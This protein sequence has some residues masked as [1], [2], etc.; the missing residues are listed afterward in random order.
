MHSMHE[1][2][3]T[4]E[5][6][7][8]SRYESVM[9]KAA[10]AIL[11]GGLAAA[12]AVFVTSPPDAAGDGPGVYVAS[13]DNSKK[14]QLELQRIGGKSAV[15]AAQFA[16]W[17]ESLWHGRRLAGTLVVLATVAAL[18]CFFASKLPPLDD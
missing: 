12:A 1:S 11:A 16:E 10:V 6:P 13:I 15:A 18:S 5:K 9:R 17:F 3:T 14:V 7:Q 4:A 8:R 2:R